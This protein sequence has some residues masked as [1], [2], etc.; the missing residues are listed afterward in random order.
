MFWSWRVMLLSSDVFFDPDQTVWAIIL[1]RPSDP[2]V[3]IVYFARLLFARTIQSS[4]H[5]IV[6]NDSVDEIRKREFVYFP[7]PP[8]DGWITSS[9][10]RRGGNNAV[11][12]VSFMC[13]CVCVWCTAALFTCTHAHGRATVASAAAAIVKGSRRS[14]AEFSLVGVL[15][16]SRQRCHVSGTHVACV[17]TVR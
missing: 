10:A 4:S 16:S 1:L 13:A 17:L 12:S 9:L 3:C 15:W 14:V 6:I 7:P 11:A 8:D 2:V 5:K